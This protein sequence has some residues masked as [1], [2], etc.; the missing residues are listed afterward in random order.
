MD[1]S[2]DPCGT[3]L[4]TFLPFYSFAFAPTPYLLTSYLSMSELSLLCNGCFVFFK[5]SGKSLCRKLSGYPSKICQ[6]G[7]IYLHSTT[8][9]CRELQEVFKTK[10]YFTEVTLVLPNRF[11]LSRC[12]LILAFLIPQIPCG[13]RGTGLLSE[14][15][16]IG[17]NQFYLTA[18]YWQ[19][20]QVLTLLANLQ[21]VWLVITLL[22]QCSRL[23]LHLA[24]M[25]SKII[26]CV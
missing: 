20:L 4:V 15:N 21:D 2:K 1:P 17:V 8:E 16:K 23:R 22:F 24:E 19:R 18:S 9:P 5:A 6:L 7:H 3:L 13:S 11:Y 10:R 14:K 12:P 26:G 25:G